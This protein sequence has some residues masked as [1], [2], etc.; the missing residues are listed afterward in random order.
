MKTK[1]YKF[2]DN[3]DLLLSKKIDLMQFVER[4]LF[5]DAEFL[6]VVDKTISP[7]STKSV[8]KTKQ[9]LFDDFVY[10]MH[11]GARSYILKVIVL[12][13]VADKMC[14][15]YE[16]LTQYPYWLNIVNSLCCD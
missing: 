6:N 11:N 3:V 8:D 13:Y 9:Q 15:N 12:K 14:K 2:T 10:Y 16:M 7:S 1:V 5:S 4:E